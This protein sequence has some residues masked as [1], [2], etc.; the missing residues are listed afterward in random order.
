MSIE[1]PGIVEV[2]LN[3]MSLV[4]EG[5]GGECQPRQ[6]VTAILQQH[7]RIRR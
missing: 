7:L 6:D 4:Q 3:A 5:G 2:T 1:Y